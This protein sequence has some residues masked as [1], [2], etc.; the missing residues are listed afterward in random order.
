LLLFLG[1][2]LATLVESAVGA[3]AVGQHRLF[4][5]RAVLD[6]HRFDV[7]VAAPCAL[8][9][10]G[11]SSLGNRHD[12]LPCR[13]CQDRGQEDMVGGGA[14]PVK[15]GRHGEA[16]PGRGPGPVSEAPRGGLADV[17]SPPRGASFTSPALQGW[18][19]PHGP[20]PAAPEPAGA[21]ARPLSW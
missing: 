17:V 16:A 15:L 3:D 9:G 5:A 18:A 13:F 21:A 11:D 10:T 2:H 4:A 1:L 19:P 8:P 20:A 14:S 7:V 12:C 6:L